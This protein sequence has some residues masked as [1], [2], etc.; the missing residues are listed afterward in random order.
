MERVQK[1]ECGPPP[2]FLNTNHIELE[3]EFDLLRKGITHASLLSSEYKSMAQMIWGKFHLPFESGKVFDEF[4]E[5]LDRRKER[6]SR[7][8]PQACDTLV[9]E[10]HWDMGYSAENCYAITPPVNTVSPEPPPYITHSVRERYLELDTQLSAVGTEISLMRLLY[11][12]LPAMPNIWKSQVWRARV[13]GREVV[14]K[15]YQACFPPDRPYISNRSG[16][17]M[18]FYLEEEEAHREAWAYSRL[19]H[20]QGTIIPHSYEFFK[21]SLYFCF[22]YDPILK[23]LLQIKLPSGDLAWVHIMEYVNGRILGGHMFDPSSSEDSLDQQLPDECTSLHRYVSTSLQPPRIITLLTYV[24]QMLDITILGY[25]AESLGVIQFGFE[26]R[27]IILTANGE[28]VLVDFGS[29]RSP[30]DVGKGHPPPEFYFD[31]QHLAV[32]DKL[33]QQAGVFPTGEWLREAR[34]ETNANRNKWD[35]LDKLEDWREYLK[36]LPIEGLESDERAILALDP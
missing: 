29:A 1:Y 19:F 27:N 31:H 4:I 7:S 28:M 33:I 30:D 2:G 22:R 16:K 14:A 18:G 24:P 10:G 8:F 6:N 21:E 32:V 26:G 12:V 17:L 5:E 36:K 23:S 25:S 3:L 35:G 34:T 20:L 13:A 11:P 15:I 9:T